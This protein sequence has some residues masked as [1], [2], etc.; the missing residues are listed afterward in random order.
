MKYI[1]LMTGKKADFDAYADQLNRFVFR[2]GQLMRPLFEAAKKSP[3]RIVYAEGEDERVLRAVQ[4]IVD[5]GIAEPI[6]IG[7][8]PVIEAR[9]KEMG[10]RIDFD[11]SVQVLDPQRDE[12]V[13]WQ[14]RFQ[15]R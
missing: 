5:D 7:R 9:A 15:I 13:A 10:L 2:S 1:L 8:R 4:T 12:P 6:L 14:P 3:R 11:E